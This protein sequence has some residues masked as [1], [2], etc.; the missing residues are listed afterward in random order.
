MDRNLEVSLDRAEELVTELHEEYRRALGQREVSDKAVHLTHEVCM[1]L[2]SVLDRAARRYWELH[3]YP[4]LSE[5]DRETAKVYFPVASDEHEFRSTI[6]RWKH[7]EA[8]H[9]AIRDYL[10][11]QQP[12]SNQANA[13]LAI[14]DDLAVQGKHIDLVPQRRV[15]DR[16]TTVSRGSGSVSWNNGVRFSGNVSVMGAPIDPRTQRIAPTPGVTERV[17]IWVSFVIDGHN[18]NASSFCQQG[19]R[20]GAPDRHRNVEGIWTLSGLRLCGFL[21]AP[22][23]LDGTDDVLAYCGYRA[24]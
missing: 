23:E 7:E 5:R 6:G 20:S 22:P 8:R 3:V 1:L 4:S 14:L 12:F 18:V 15:E 2:R 19:M 11:N 13:W 9:Q 24:A 16:R 10:L 21:S 17:E